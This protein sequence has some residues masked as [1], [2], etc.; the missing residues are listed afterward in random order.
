MI[1][2]KLP[3]VLGHPSCLELST[4]MISVIKTYPWQCME[5]KTCI[6]CMD[7][8]DEVGNWTEIWET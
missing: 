8:Y 5:C 3:Y 4:E 2:N 6:E 7:P 1:Q